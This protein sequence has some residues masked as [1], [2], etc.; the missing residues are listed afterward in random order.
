M[1]LPVTSNLTVY[2][3][4]TWS[5]GFR[6]LRDDLPVDL[7]GATVESE[8]RPTNNG[9]HSAAT[10]IPLQVDVTN[11]PNGEISLS[12]PS[13]LHTMPPA[14]YVYDIEIAEADTTVTT[15][16]RGTLTVLRDV[17]NELA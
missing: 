2:R 1:G 12:L 3:G 10:R 9:H 5:Q 17:T 15:W 16:I 11:A 7:T 14:D 6:F 4:D 8:A 13:D